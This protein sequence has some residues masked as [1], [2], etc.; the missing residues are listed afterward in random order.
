MLVVTSDLFARSIDTYVLKK[1][2]SYKCIQKRRKRMKIDNQHA[3]RLLN[4]ANPNMV[5]GVV[6]AKSLPQSS[7]EK[8]L[9]FLID[10][11]KSAMKNKEVTVITITTN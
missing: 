4:G 11:A 10:N 2:T 1:V 8:E 7:K 5:D 9:K 6:L 3:K